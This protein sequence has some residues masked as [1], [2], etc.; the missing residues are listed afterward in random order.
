MML[1]LSVHYVRDTSPDGATDTAAKFSLGGM[2]N[3]WLG[4]DATA[5]LEGRSRNYLVGGDLRIVPIDWFFLKG[6]AGVYADKLTHALKSTPL[7]GAGVL[8]HINR[9]VYFVT[10]SS[11]FSVNDRS[12]ITFGAGL[13]FMF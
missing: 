11:Y 9:D 8:A 5:L 10:E 13:G 1:D 3:E 12:N 4:L 2:F 7:A 6:G